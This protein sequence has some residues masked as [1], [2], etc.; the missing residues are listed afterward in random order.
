L[1]SD[2]HDLLEAG[3]VLGLL[4]GTPAD[5]FEKLSSSAQA[6]DAHKIESLIEE[7]AKARAEKDWTKA[8]A[9]RNRLREMGIILEDTPRGTTWRYDL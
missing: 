7:R 5:F 3:S 6:I 8:D 4:E 9:V 1:E 2:C